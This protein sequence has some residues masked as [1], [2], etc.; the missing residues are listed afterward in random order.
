MSNAKINKARERHFIELFKGAYPNFPAGKIIAD[1]NQE[2]P[3]AIVV[4][5]QGKVGIEI[6]SLHDDKLK[7][8]ESECEKAVLE[9]RKIYEKLKLPKLHV[10][11]HI[12]GENSFN[13]TNRERFATAIANLVA[14]NVPPPGKYVAVKN[15]F[16]DPA[17]FPYEIDSIYIYQY[18]WPDE[19][20]WTAP[21]AGLYRENFVD[22]LQN[23]ISEKDLKLNGYMPDCK[24]QWLLVVA[25]NSSPSTFFDP[26]EITVSHSYKSAFDKVFVMELFRVKLFE[27]KLVGNLPVIQR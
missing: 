22:E 6:T 17:R 12:G 23:V 3:D 25:E 7:R 20:N 15:D 18:S 14:A 10:S 16:N 26:S 19:N 2:R 8:R 5:D 11:V 1:E 21:S 9:A 24:E 13:R 4:T 27:L